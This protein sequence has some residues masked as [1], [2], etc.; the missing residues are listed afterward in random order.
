MDL[1]LSARADS[2]FS[3]VGDGVR[4]EILE[5]LRKGDRS[6]GEIAAS[7]DIS[8]PAVSR[9]L[10]ILREAKLV[11]ERRQGR[12]RLYALNRAL[13]RDLFG[14]WVAAFDA[15]WLE[16][17]EALKRTVESDLDRKRGKP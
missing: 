11:T 16:N 3:A 15:M 8:W 7:F 2:A 6:A 4:R 17:L 9:H 5:Q 13:I 12:T 14:G 1:P 10:R